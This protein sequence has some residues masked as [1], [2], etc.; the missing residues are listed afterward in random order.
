ME[1]QNAVAHAQEVA[2]QAMA[3]MNQMCSAPA[4]MPQFP[5]TVPTTVSLDAMLEVLANEPDSSRP[6][7]IDWGARDTIN[8]RSGRVPP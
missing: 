7:V 4:I 8:R 2:N 5:T 1:A 3:T 6:S